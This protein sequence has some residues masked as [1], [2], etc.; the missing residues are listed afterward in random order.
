MAKK[1]NE[2]LPSYSNL[3]AGRQLGNIFIID[4]ME[5]SNM[6][7]VLSVPGAVDLVDSDASAV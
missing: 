6:M 1:G 5:T 4:F 7:K 3:F 2:L